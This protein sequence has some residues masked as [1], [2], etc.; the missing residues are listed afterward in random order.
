M[1]RIDLALEETTKLLPKKV[2]VLITQSCPTLCELVDCSL[3]DFTWNSL[4]KNT[5]L[6]CYFLLE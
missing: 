3:P 4:G 6:G 2:K 5:G 1:A